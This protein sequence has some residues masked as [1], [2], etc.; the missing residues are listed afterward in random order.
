M[1]LPDI[2]LEVDIEVV[3]SNANRD[4][5]GRNVHEGSTSINDGSSN[6]WWERQCISGALLWQHVESA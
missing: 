4:E 5:G 1:P 2:V 3:D 6:M